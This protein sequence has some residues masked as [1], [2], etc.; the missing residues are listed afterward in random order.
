MNF[1]VK[2]IVPTALGLLACAP[3]CNSPKVDEMAKKGIDQQRKVTQAQGVD[4]PM[5]DDTRVANT[6][7]SFPLLPDNRTQVED[8]SDRAIGKK[9]SNKEFRGPGRAEDIETSPN[10]DLS[11]ESIDEA[12]IERI[13]AESEDRKTGSTSNYTTERANEI[14]VASENVANVSNLRED[15]DSRAD[16]K[17]SLDQINSI[18]S[19]GLIEPRLDLLEGT[20]NLPILAENGMPTK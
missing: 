7:N 11:K 4:T 18:H 17:P 14:G 2:K 10:M 13:K 6:E 15:T 9:L 8:S 20:I 3:G 19:K 5:M 16:N 12:D 1:G